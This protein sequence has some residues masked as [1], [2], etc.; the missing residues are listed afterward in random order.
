MRLS[1]LGERELL[2]DERRD[3]LLFEQVQQGDQVLSEQIG[4]EP[5]ERLDAVGDDA[6][7]A[8]KN[9]SPGDVHA[10]GGGSRKTLTL[11]RAPRCQSLAPDRGSEPVAHH[12]SAA[13]ERLPGL[14]EVR[15]AKRIE[16][17]IDAVA[18]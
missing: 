13:T 15:S 11:A 14:P 7:P 12:P 17:G 9:P 10:E 1:R 6:L 2:G 4:L 8:W 5:L 3:L 18:G 16:N